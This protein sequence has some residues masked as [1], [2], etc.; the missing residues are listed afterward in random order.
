MVK[1]SSSINFNTSSSSRQSIK[2]AFESR[3]SSYYDTAMVEWIC[4]AF[5]ITTNDCHC[6]ILQ[7][8]FVQCTDVQAATKRM[9]WIGV[10]HLYGRMPEFKSISAS[11]PS[12]HFQGLLLCCD[13]VGESA[14]LPDIRER[15]NRRCVCDDSIR[16]RFVSNIL[17]LA[18][19]YSRVI[20]LFKKWRYVT[21]LLCGTVAPDDDDIY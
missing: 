15:R 8:S 19:E 7:F 9:H 16:H 14:E 1:Y 17:W 18:N 13:T 3:K 10:E 21:V 5:T 2:Y 4:S 20:Y 12:A 6:F 11:S